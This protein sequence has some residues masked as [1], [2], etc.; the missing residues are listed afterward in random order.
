M[1]TKILKSTDLINITA[2]AGNQGQSL[3]FFNSKFALVG[4]WDTA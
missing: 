3:K 1:K 4:H 2:E